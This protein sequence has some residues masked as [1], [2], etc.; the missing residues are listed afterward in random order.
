MVAQVKEVKSAHTRDLL[1]KRNVVGVGLGYKI[2]EGVI[3][4]ELS[5]VVS[6]THKRDPSVLEAQDLV[7]QQVDGVRTDV[8]ETGPLYAFDLGP[9][10]RWRPVV[11][12]GVS[13]GHFR[14][15]AGTF[16]CLVRRG[17]EVF[18]LSN[19]HVLANVNEAQAGDHI[20]QPGPADHGTA[21]DHV[22]S[23]ADFVPLD[24]GTS[25]PECPFAEWSA[26]LLNAVA[27]AL[28]SHHKLEAVRQ[29]DGVNHV[30]AALARP[31]SPDL[32]TNEILHI[33]APAGIG[34][35][36]LGTEV[37][38]TGRTTDYTQGTIT[39]VDATVRIDYYGPSALFTDQLIAT[40]M[41]EPGDSGSAV[42]DMEQRVVGLLFAGSGAAT[43][44]NP[45]DAVLTALNV[46]L[47][48]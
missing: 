35:A 9:R 43:V 29:T 46:E 44:I 14:I 45:I 23:L 7:P 24:F 17:E 12:P 38:K 36:T 2:S 47:A 27:G 16:G 31:L 28:G 41:S 30:D 3:T 20:L 21:A 10:D 18:I 4:D 25:A 22:A 32:V 5:L 13:V 19:N 26:K 39:Q 34:E 1:A 40:P 15:T 8:V 33:G 11:P 37:Q 48:L 6:V 42:L